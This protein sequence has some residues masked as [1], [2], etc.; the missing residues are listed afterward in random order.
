MDQSEASLCTK[1]TPSAVPFVERR[2]PIQLRTLRFAETPS[3]YGSSCLRQVEGG[4]EQHLGLIVRCASLLHCFAKHLARG[5]EDS[6]TGHD[7][8]RQR[9][10]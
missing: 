7:H 4:N 2:F 1:G 3:P 5:E 6:P 8:Q 10:S 9:C